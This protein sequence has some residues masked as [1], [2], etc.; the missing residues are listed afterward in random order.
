MSFNWRGLDREEMERH[1][2]PRVACPDAQAFLE[3]FARDSARARETL[4]G[5]Y[6]LRYGERPKETLDVHVPDGER[7]DRALVLFIHGGYWRALDKSDHSFVVPPLLASGAVVVNINYDLCPTVSLDVIVDE[8]AGA[9]RFCHANATRWGAD[10]N[11][12]FLVGHSAGAHLAAAMLQ[13][14]WSDDELA[15]GAIRGVAGLTGVYEPQVIL[16]V[17]VNEEAQ[18]DEFSAARNDCVARS[19]THKPP[20]LLAVGADEPNGWIGQTD[21]FAA[22]CSASGVPAERLLVRDANHF[23]VLQRAV[24]PDHELGQAVIGL[25]R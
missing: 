10:P 6:D 20:V 7:R 23:T 12:L 5:Q 3:E 1:F 16:D 24:D 13:R 15:P 8:I 21:A 18:I 4:P 22:H 9:V 14:P 11:A 25:W 17:S 19:F 2:N